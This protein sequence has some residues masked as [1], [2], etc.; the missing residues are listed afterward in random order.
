MS[1]MRI[2][3]WASPLM[4]YLLAIGSIGLGLMVLLVLEGGLS[5]IGEGDAARRHLPAAATLLMACSFTVAVFVARD[6]R[7]HRKAAEEALERLSRETAERLR[8]EHAVDTFFALSITPMCVM[9]FDGYPKRLNAAWEALVGLPA[10]VLEARPVIEFVHAADIEATRGMLMDLEHGAKVIGFENRVVSPDGTVR[11]LSW[12]AVAI[13]DQ[14]VFMINAKDITER[15]VHEFEAATRTEKLERSN[16]DLERFAFMASHDLQ[17]PLRMVASYA[18]QLTK[19]YKG[20]LD[21]RADRYIAYVVDGALRMQ[22]M[23]SSLLSYSRMEQNR[24][25][26]ENLSTVDSV[27]VALRNLQTAIQESAAVV[28]YDPLPSLRA[29]PAMLTHLFQNL[30]GNAIKFRGGGAPRVHIS[31]S[32]GDGE[33]IFSVADEGIGIRPEDA[34]RVFGLFQ[35]LHSKAE[36]PGSGMGLAIC[37]KIVQRH[38]GRIWVESEVGKGSRFYFSVKQRLNLVQG[39]A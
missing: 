2:Y 6:A 18:Q 5:G 15:K 32:E 25:V 23:I 24:P 21:A 29:D 34:E 12:N 35:R 38:G 36:Y 31:A 9:G 28:T 8:A 11:W 10:A 30:V 14:Q 26:Y 39:A 4:A 20:Q 37:Q 13:A 16:A 17:E 33:W 3:K 7:R 1:S 22:G 19:H 27:A